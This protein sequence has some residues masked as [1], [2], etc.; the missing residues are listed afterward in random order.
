MFTV[1]V[2]LVVPETPVSPLPSSTAA[3]VV[4]SETSL[5]SS[6]KQTRR[7]LSSS[8]PLLVRALASVVVAVAE[9]DVDAVVAALLTAMFV[10][11]LAAVLV[12][13][14][15]EVVVAATG[16]ELLRA[17]TVE[18]SVDHLLVALVEPATAHLP[19]LLVMVVEVVLMVVEATATHLA[20]P[21]T[22]G[23]K[24]PKSVTQRYPGPNSFFTLDTLGC[25][26]ASISLP[27]CLRSG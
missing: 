14:A 5:I 10:A 4:L 2:V 12:D 20:L 21:E 22:L 1:S 16:E 9:V 18:A 23:G 15:A 27:C 25:R 7:F 3:I 8:S 6:K 17:A 19:L 26:L 13:S 11:L 24:H